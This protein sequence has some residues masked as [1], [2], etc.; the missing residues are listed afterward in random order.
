[1]FG[2][3]KQ[4]SIGDPFFARVEQTEI[5]LN[6]EA[7]QDLAEKSGVSESW[8]N[9]SLSGLQQFAAGLVNDVVR[10]G[11]HDVRLGNVVYFITN[12]KGR[13]EPTGLSWERATLT[14]GF[15]NIVVSTADHIFND[16]E[17]RQD[18]DMTYD[19]IVE[20]LQ[21]LMDA[22][23]ADGTLSSDDLPALPSEEQFRQAQETGEVLAIEPRKFAHNVATNTPSFFGSSSADKSTLDEDADPFAANVPR[24][25]A[26]KNPQS[27]Q[28]ASGGI[29]KPIVQAVV[30]TQD[31]T[32]GVITEN[33]PTQ[34]LIDRVN[35][36]PNAFEM[37]DVKADL[38]AEHPDYVVSRL[39]ADKA[40]A[41]D[42]LND[43]S[44][45]YTQK[46]R[47][48]MSDLLKQQQA[49]AKAAVEQL[50]DT[51]VS[52]TVDAQMKEERATEFETR[53]AQAHQ[54]REAGYRTAVE[55]ENA[56]H[57]NTLKTLKSEFVSDLETLKVS[58]NQELDNW[59]IERSKDLQSNLQATVDDQ[60][61]EVTSQAQTETLTSLKALRDELLA[62]NTQSLLDMHQKLEED[63]SNKRAQYQSEHEKAMISATELESAKTHAGSLSELE[64]QVQILKQTNLNI[65]QQ[66]KGKDAVNND[67]VSQ[68]RQ[69]LQMLQNAPKTSSHDET[70]QQL[71]T[72]LAAQIK[73]PQVEQKKTSAWQS[74][75]IGFLAV[76][77]IGGAGFG[78][79]AMAQHKTDATA[80]SSK[81]VSASGHKEGNATVTLAPES[82][83]AGSS[84]KVSAS[85][86][87]SS[88]SSSQA[89]TSS[90]LADRYHVGEDVD[91]TIN[92]QTVTAK[93]VSVQDKTITVHHD[94]Y[95]YV[96][97]FDN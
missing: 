52:E 78:G 40:K 28:P 60:V 33:D 21:P 88:S 91:A 32:E 26:P 31:N 25:V 93:V 73:Q 58:V 74:S 23:L 67:E 51:N 63:I 64:Q 89:N 71:M 9:V 45:I 75:A 77:A 6:D 80:Q 20:A 66:L 27:E 56:R 22:V 81:A 35:L 24:D 61:S 8:P 49:K 39:N 84:S 72:L 82:S 18:E 7:I 47:K 2:K 10:A 15:E 44:N 1:M 76:L 43:T 37:S 29:V 79:Y 85:S 95:D 30:P 16:T 5:D 70:N 50:R 59:F 53:Y 17:I 13:A 83:E 68:L 12:E 34:K 14:A 97:P 69:R 42:F 94:G 86:S 90:T 4:T 54:A 55:D 57:D 36:S 48:A 46:I 96:V 65:E 38:P 87:Q 3:K 11:D 92:G 41:N 62:Q 19:I